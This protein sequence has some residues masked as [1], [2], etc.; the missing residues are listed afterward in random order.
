LPIF[1]KDVGNCKVSALRLDWKGYFVVISRM[2]PC[3]LFVTFEV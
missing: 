2:L 1:Q 3:Y